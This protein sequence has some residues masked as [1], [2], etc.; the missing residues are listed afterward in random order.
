HR[1]TGLRGCR[2]GRIQVGVATMSTTHIDLGVTGMTCTSCSSRVER[3]LNKI[4]GVTAT[5]NYATESASVE[6]DPTVTGPEELIKVVQGAGYDAYD[7][8][9]ASHDDAEPSDA[10]SADSSPADIAR[11]Q[12]AAQLKRLTI[13]SG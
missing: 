7:A 9:P 4:D 6:Y 8:S 3:K 2:R 13:M 11:E 5:V 1:R 12:E 10:P